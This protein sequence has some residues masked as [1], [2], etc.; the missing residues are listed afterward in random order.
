MK[1]K[2]LIHGKVQGIFFRKF[3]EVEALE[4]GLQGYVRN[5]PDGGVEAVFQGDENK[6]KEMI[7]LCRRGAEGSDV[8]KVVV[9]DYEG[10]G[11]DDFDVRY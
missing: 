8:E 11:F 7:G 2:V 6:I 5:L 10:E 1:K 9:E 4:L 3:V